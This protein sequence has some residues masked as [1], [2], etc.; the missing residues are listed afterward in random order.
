[1]METLKYQYMVKT[2]TM[3]RSFNLLSSRVHRPWPLHGLPKTLRLLVKPLN[4]HLMY[5]ISRIISFLIT[6]HPLKIRQIRSLLGLIL[7]E[8]LAFLVYICL[9]FPLYNLNDNEDYLI[10]CRP[11]LQHSVLLLTKIHKV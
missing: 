4:T 7:C 2:T 3:G 1:R 6:N 8:V 9:A 11:H 5:R 10:P